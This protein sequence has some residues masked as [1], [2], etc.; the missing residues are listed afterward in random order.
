[1]NL[2]SKLMPT[3]AALAAAVELKPELPVYQFHPMTPHAEFSHYTTARTMQVLEA[4]SLERRRQEALLNQGKLPFT[5]AD[6]EINHA[7]K[8]AVLTEELGE[9][10]KA[11]YEL[12]WLAP[13]DDLEPYRAALRT[14]L[15]Q[16]AAVA[17]AWAESI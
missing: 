9:V 12:R 14:E 16:V 17:V 10:G 8:L 13:P 7:D 1:M 6:P 11:L 5:C 4:V 2:L 3:H 15:I